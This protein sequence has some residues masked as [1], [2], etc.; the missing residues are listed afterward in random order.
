MEIPFKQLSDEILQ[1]II[2]EYLL[3]E[4]SNYGDNAPELE[5]SVSRVK[6]ELARGRLSI[7]FDEKSETCGIL[8]QMQIQQLETN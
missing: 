8:N 4:E 5:Q 2:E 1:N 7:Y 6:Q 3:R